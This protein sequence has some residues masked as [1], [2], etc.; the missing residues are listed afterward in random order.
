[1][2]LLQYFLILSVVMLMGLPLCAWGQELSQV[3]PADTFST[4]HFRIMYERGISLENVRG[5]ADDIELIF[6]DFNAKVMLRLPKEIPTVL[7]SSFVGLMRRLSGRVESPVFLIH[8][9]L[10]IVSW[11]DAGIARD[12]VLPLLRYAIAFTILDRGS[13]HGTPQWLMYGYALRYANLGMSITPPP[14]AYMRSFDDFTEEGQQFISHREA[15][16]Y[17]YLLLKAIDFL[18]TRYGEQ[19]FITLFTDI[20]SD[21]TLE[22]GFEKAFGEKYT[23]IEK[24]WRTYIDTQVGK[25]VPRKENEPKQQEK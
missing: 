9:T 8:D 2:K 21:K 13:T 3:V 17:N 24:A 11:N 7:G 18:I 15:G 4:P 10:Y 23:T 12:R 20:P 5:V 14:V 6:G 25:S 22:E 19:K 16:N 1:M